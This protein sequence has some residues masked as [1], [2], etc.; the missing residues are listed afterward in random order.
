MRVFIAFAVKY[1][2]Q[3][4]WPGLGDCVSMS[5]RLWHAPARFGT[6][7]AQPDSV[8]HW[9][10]PQLESNWAGVLSIYT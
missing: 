3:T 2:E 5:M 7:A 1:R 9:P 6:R 8:I 10:S 4:A